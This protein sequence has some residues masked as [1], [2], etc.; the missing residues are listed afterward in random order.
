M[1]FDKN[2]ATNRLLFALSQ[3]PEGMTTHEL[4]EFS[5]QSNCTTCSLLRDSSYA[6]EKNAAEGGSADMPA[7]P[8]KLI[9]SV[10][11][12]ASDE[13]LKKRIEAGS[14]G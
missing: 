14:R 12:S 6:Q 1:A 4:A 10:C 13:D 9:H 3:H 8:W 11:G 7:A 5:Q 2:Q